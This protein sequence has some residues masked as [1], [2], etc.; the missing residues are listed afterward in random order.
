MKTLTTSIFTIMPIIN[1]I[2]MALTGG[3]FLLLAGSSIVE[4]E[5][6]AAV[7]SFLGLCLNSAVWVLFNH[8]HHVPFIQTVNL[9]VWGTIILFGIISLIKFFPKPPTRDYSKIEPMDER[10]AM[11]SRNNLG[12]HPHL[13]EQYYKKHPEKK[14]TDAKIHEKPEIG[15]PG[16]LYY[17]EYYSPVFDA[18]FNYLSQTRPATWGEPAKEKK[19]LNEKA[20][21]KISKVVRE[22]GRYYGAVDM[23]I[24][25]IKPY[26]F[27]SH[28][29]RHAENWGEK[30]ES[31]DKSAIV[32]IVAMD[33]EMIQGCPTLPAILES[34]RHYV[35]AAKIATIISQY[36]RDLG[37]AARAQTDGNYQA[38][39]VPCALDAGLGELG[40]LGLLMHPIYGPCVRISVV[41]TE[42]ELIP[43]E[44]KHFAI[45][46][47]N[48]FCK[49]CKK[50]ADNCPTQSIAQE[51]EPTSR[52]FR[53]W[54]INQETCFSY[55]KNIGTDCAFCI[56]VCPY[57]KPNT[58]LHKLVRFYISRNPIN[59]QIALRMDDLFYGR[60][61]KIPAKNPKKMIV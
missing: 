61:K 58:L 59:Q 30:V 1:W 60:H 21:K 35:E 15:E 20:I 5:T 56:R 40:R 31:N 33:V 47:I 27:Y 17:D 2:L 32:I 34:S 39:C 8:F 37:Y 54:S 6:R 45:G 28:R 14:E 49:I 12:R 52:G 13:A 41:T 53:H 3:F 57:T 43:T 25:K 36:I 10:D 19:Q 46:S 38:M 7:I 24:T 50:C 48:H 42:L 18:A 16:A 23:G 9:A 11:F 29:G 22:I 55:W 26:H 44:S 51:D 4:K